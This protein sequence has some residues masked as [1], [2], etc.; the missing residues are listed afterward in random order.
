M[1]DYVCPVC[2]QKARREKSQGNCPNCGKKH[3]WVY[4]PKCHCRARL[5]PIEDSPLAHPDVSAQI[6]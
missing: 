6:D 1:T 5:V 4:K 2:G 3:M